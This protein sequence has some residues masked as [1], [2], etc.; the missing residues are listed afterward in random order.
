MILLA[1]GIVLAA[2]LVGV[3]PGLIGVTKHQGEDREYAA[4][5]LVTAGATMVALALGVLLGLTT[6]SGT[7]S[8]VPRQAAPEQISDTTADPPD[9]N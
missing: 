5:S 1:V 3:P 6:A 8:G 9:S 7:L 2:E 4:A